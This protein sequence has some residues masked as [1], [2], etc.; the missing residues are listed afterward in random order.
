MNT[1]IV[2]LFHQLTLGVYIIGVAQE[3]KRDAFTAAA[4]MQVSYS[5]L[6]LALAI[7]P[8]HASYPLLCAGGSFTVS[9]LAREQLELARRFGTAAPGCSDKMAGVVWR[10]GRGGAP[11]LASALGYFDCER[12][13]DIA[14]GDHRLIVGQVRDGAVLRRGTAPL[15]YADTH[16][17]D[18]SSALYPASFARSPG[19]K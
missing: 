12:Q 18:G 9:V 6:L 1:E 13:E 3:S 8:K 10:T 2:G 7:N 14:A 19:A 4:L 16:D 5:P 17:I 11:I 15:I